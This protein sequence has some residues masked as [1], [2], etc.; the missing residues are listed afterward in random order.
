MGEEAL[1]APLENEDE[2]PQPSKKKLKKEIS[3]VSMDS[4]GY[5]SLL[6]TPEAVTP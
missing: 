3:D 5:P 1:P 6:K 2:S 4:K